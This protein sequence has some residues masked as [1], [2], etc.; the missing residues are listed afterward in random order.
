MWRQWIGIRRVVTQISYPAGLRAGD[1][2]GACHLPLRHIGDYA[3]GGQVGLGLLQL[4]EVGLHGSGSESSSCS[5]DSSGDYQQWPYLCVRL[6]QPPAADS[7]QN[8]D[9]GVM[10][11]TRTGSRLTAGD[12]VTVLRS[13][14]EHYSTWDYILPGTCRH[15]ADTSNSCSASATSPTCSLRP[16]RPSVDR[17]GAHSEQSRR[18]TSGGCD[19]E[20]RT[21]E[22]GPPL[23][24][25][26]RRRIELLDR[27]GLP[28]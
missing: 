17:R 10:V 20:L 8:N 28:T 2:S 1:R 4:R 6:D 18:E 13:Y 25:G 26:A 23:G 19:P 3:H 12:R 5:S 22:L 7:S 14:G 16:G 27:P 11:N 9:L 21:G 24:A 15:C